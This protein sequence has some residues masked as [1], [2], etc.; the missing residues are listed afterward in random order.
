[1]TQKNT[2]A[3]LDSIKMCKTQANIFVAKFKDLVLNSGLT[4]EKDIMQKFE[5]TLPQHIRERIDLGTEPTTA[6]LYYK[7]AKDRQNVE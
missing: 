7:A 2:L 6:E 1:M 5:K 3:E 4:S